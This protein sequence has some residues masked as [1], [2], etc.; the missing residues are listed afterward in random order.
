[1]NISRERL[2]INRFK[3]IQPGIRTRVI[4]II[5]GVTLIFTLVTVIYTHTTLQ[6]TMEEQLDRKGM[7]LAQNQ[8]ARSV[9]PVLTNNIFEL[10]EL[11]YETLE[12]ND[13]VVYVF[14]EDHEGN[15]LAHTFQ[16]YFPP[17]LKEIEH[18][19][20]GNTGVSLRK[21]SAEDG[22]LRDIA[23]PVFETPE[24]DVK[25][26]MGVMDYSIQAALT[27]ITYQ[28]LGI[29]AATFVVLSILVYLF[30]TATTVRPLNSLL[31][32]V[33][34]V[35]QG[36]LSQE[37]KVNTRDELSQLAQA[38]N[39]MTR[40]LKHTREVRDSLLKRIINTQEEERHRISREL[41][42]DTGQALN[43]LLISLQ[44]LESSRDSSEFQQRSKEL[45]DLL[46]QTL[47]QVRLLAW[48][49]SPT[50]LADLGLKAALES[51]LNK[52]EEYTGW[53]L[54]VNFEGLERRR[55]PSEIEASVYRIVQEALT[56]ISRHA[57]ARKVHV[58][59]KA[60][61]HLLTVNITDDGAGFNAEDFNLEESTQKS[62][63]LTSMQERAAL[64]GG[65]FQID[66][67]SGK[68]TTVY[69]EVPLPEEGQE[70]EE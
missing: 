33:Q 3:Y 11:A 48:R 21:F 20:E 22:V 15:I 16:D 43:T 45:R 42:D 52:Y 36:D 70:E 1:M 14:L 29:S 10:N 58:Q 4:G 57:G 41:H 60:L 64:V 47:E 54:Q 53:E 50:P 24:P 9:E 40:R 62:L 19:I 65:T 35:S 18:D 38:F 13:D 5:L 26:R 59:V 12:N 31:N 8:A 55:L 32:S 61:S 69:V 23:V 7:S 51:F 49:L 63:G 27:S 17:E 37:V 28:T 67:A 34:A 25:V 56:N 30:T 39:N 6:Q 66:S 46:L 68:G 2:N 44:L